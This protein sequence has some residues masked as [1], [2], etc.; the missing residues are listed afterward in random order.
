MLMRALAAISIAATLLSASNCTTAT[1]S[2]DRSIES[3]IPA[4]DLPTTDLDGHPLPAA[5]LATVYL[6]AGPECPISRSYCPELA[7]LAARD[8]A[9]GISWV[10]VFS[11]YDISAEAIRTFQREYSIPLPSIID[12]SQQL[13]CRIGATVIPSVVVIDANR[14]ILYRG[15]IDDRYKA[16]GVSYGPPTKRDLADVVDAIA[17]GHPRPFASTAA[18]GC[19]LPRC[20]P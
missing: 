7:R 16:L 5:T 14:H 6:F 13:A 19:V 8:R 9:R 10:M 2:K 1:A 11:E 20:T 18:V 3:I 17:A 15:R 4:N 12:S